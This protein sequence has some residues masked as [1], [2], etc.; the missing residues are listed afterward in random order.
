MIGHRGAGAI[1]LAGLLS[2]SGGLSGQVVQ[3]GDL[4]LDLT[5]RVQFQL[6]TTSVDEEDIGQSLPG[7]VFETRRVR[8]GSTFAYGEWIT[9]K[10]EADFSGSGARLTDGFIDLALTDGLA[11]RAGQFKK[12]FGVIELESSTR[13]PLIERGLRLRGVEDLVGVPGETQWLLDEGRYLGRQVGVMAHGGQGALGYEVGVFNGE[14]ANTRETNGSK[15]YTG[16]LT[17]AV[18]G[19]LVVGGAVSVQPTGVFLGDDE[20]YGTVFSLEG[21]WGGFRRPGLHVLGELM[22]GENAVVF[23]DGEPAGMVGA[24]AMAAWFSSRAGRVEGVE[25]ALR[26]S[27]AD[28]DTDADDDTG[29]LVTPGVNFYF[30]GRNRLML[31][32][33]AYFPGQDGLDAEYGVV[34]QLQVYF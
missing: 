18:A 13:I 17:Y 1:I 28:P 14:G 12:P 6:N 33:E 34:A 32:G 3:A 22:F 4:E 23:T 30:T 11:V 31:N 26:V 21:E 24:H 15:A 5:G 29:L 10:V 2:W 9:G 20:E 16:R 27:W 25:P 8:F 19:P 7:V